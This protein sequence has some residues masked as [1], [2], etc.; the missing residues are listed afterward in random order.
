[1]GLNDDAI[2]LLIDT[3]YTNESLDVVIESTLDL[4]TEYGYLDPESENAI[5]IT[6]STDTP[7]ETEELE[8]KVSLKVSKFIEARKM[9]VE[10][11]KASLE[12]TANIKELA[13]QY[14]IS[15]GKVKIITRALA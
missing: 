5:L 12:A 2:K 13:E 7:E 4:A 9:H 14:N 11:L 15:V 10:V 8:K 1:N 3:N 6:T